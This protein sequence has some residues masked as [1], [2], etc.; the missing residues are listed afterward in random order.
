MSSNRIG[1]LSTFSGVLYASYP[2]E[3]GNLTHSEYNTA[4]F[5]CAINLVYFLLFHLK[6][7]SPKMSF[8]GCSLKGVSLSFIWKCIALILS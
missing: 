8:L 5:S 2:T 4:N 7:F 6:F 3:E 1:S